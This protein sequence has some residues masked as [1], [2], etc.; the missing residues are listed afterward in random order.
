M[1]KSGD[2]VKL[3]IDPAI[4]NSAPWSLSNDSW[5][6]FIKLRNN[7]LVTLRHIEHDKTGMPGWAVWEH[8]NGSGWDWIPEQWLT[9]ANTHTVGSIE[10]KA[11]DRCRVNL[12]DIAEINSLKIRLSAG[13]INFIGRVNGREIFLNEFFSYEGIDGWN[14]TGETDNYGWCWIPSK[15]LKPTNQKSIDI[16][17]INT[18]AK[19][20]NAWDGNPTYERSK[21]IELD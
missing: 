3:Q 12:V 16:P 17:I 13:W 5:K 18:I 21:R 7:T 20:H 19:Q 14:T 11:G 9:D 2:K 10:L 6:E 4:L 15:W 8:L 1:R